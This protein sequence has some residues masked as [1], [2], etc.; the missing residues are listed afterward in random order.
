M[1]TVRKTPKNEARKPQKDFS[2]FTVKLDMSGF[3]AAGLVDVLKRG[4]ILLRREAADKLAKM[5]ESAVTALTGVLGDECANVSAKRAAANALKDNLD[6]LPLKEK[7]LASL[8]L[9]KEDDVVGMGAPA[10]PYLIDILKD[11]D[12]SSLLTVDAAKALGRIIGEKSGYDP[13]ETAVAL[14]EVLKVP[15]ELEIIR[16][17]VTRGIGHIARAE[18]KSAEE[19]IREIRLQQFQ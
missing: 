12:S 18:G 5:E 9:E 19:L 13:D 3:D 1:R 15:H 17:W 4:N 14:S 10:M 7:V 2:N 16:Y 11:V 6:K 8:L